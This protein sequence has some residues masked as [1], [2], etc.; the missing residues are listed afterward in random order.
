MSKILFKKLPRKTGF[1]FRLDDIAPNMNWEMM[2]RVKNLFNKYNTKP[3]LGV[4]PKNEDVHL[5]KY[6]LC[7]FNFWDEIKNLKKQGWQIAMHGYEHSYDR[8]SKK[9]RLY[10]LWREQ[11]ICGS[12]F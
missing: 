12:F 10:G 11:R 3:I 2:N 7:K 4:I 6:P 9:K 8:Y 1:I 5:K